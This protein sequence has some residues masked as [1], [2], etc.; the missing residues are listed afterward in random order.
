M[1]TSLREERKKQ[2]FKTILVRSHDGTIK[3][4]LH[5]QELMGLYDFINNVL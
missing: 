4:K 2:T 1:N 5:R 3:E